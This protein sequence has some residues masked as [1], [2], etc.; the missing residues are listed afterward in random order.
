[1]PAGQWRSVLCLGSRRRAWLF[2]V[3]VLSAPRV[4]VRHEVFAFLI[5]NIFINFFGLFF[6][7]LNNRRL[8]IM[9]PLGVAQRGRPRGKKEVRLSYSRLGPNSASRILPTRLRSGKIEIILSSDFHFGRFGWPTI[10]CFY[11]NFSFFWAN[12]MIIHLFL[13]HFRSQ[14]FFIF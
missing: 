2:I 6:V 13:C 5:F 9:N 14:N 4:K 12:F 1:M 7:N 3:S 10:P 11:P 8:N